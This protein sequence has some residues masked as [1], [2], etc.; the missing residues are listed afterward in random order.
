MDREL[1]YRLKN[2][3]DEGE[4]LSIDDLDDIILRK[5]WWEESV[6]DSSI[7]ELFD[8]TPY[9]IKKLRYDLGIKFHDCA[10]LDVFSKL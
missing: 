9:K 2:R 4:K 5:L 3:K 6:S 10:L 1:Y 7:A 8:T